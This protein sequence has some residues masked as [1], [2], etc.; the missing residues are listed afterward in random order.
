MF[1]FLPGPCG[2]LLQIAVSDVAGV[3]VQF[4][5]KATVIAPK[6]WQLSRSVF[7]GQNWTSSRKASNFRLSQI[8][9]YVVAIFRDLNHHN[10]G[11]LH[12]LHSETPIIVDLITFPRH[13]KS[14]ISQFWGACSFRRYQFPILDP[15]PI[16]LESFGGKS[17]APTHHVLSL[18]SYKV[19]PA[20]W[21][22]IADW[23]FNMTKRSW[24]H[25]FI[26]ENECTSLTH[27]NA[28]IYFPWIF[29][30]YVHNTQ[31]KKNVWTIRSCARVPACQDQRIKIEKTLLWLI[32]S[33]QT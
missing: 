33:V 7:I 17:K 5:L 3:K 23:E 29:T 24:L 2:I 15:P 18:T 32:Y 9:S 21:V 14:I 20:M 13:T 16:D 4:W 25:R 6:L 31:N 28:H 12:S 30:T 22:C 27:W 11:P 26:S 8:S 1:G 10:I 19:I